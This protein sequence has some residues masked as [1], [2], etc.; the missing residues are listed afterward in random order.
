MAFPSRHSIGITGNIGSGKSE[1][2]R[3]F[4]SLGAEVISADALAKEMEEN[5]PAVKRRI[6]AQ[7]GDGL[8]SEDGRLNRKAVARLIFS[9]DAA[10]EKLNAIVH[11]VVLEAIGK[12]MEAFKK[13]SGQPP[14]IVVESA[15]IYEAGMLEMFDYIVFV[16]APA[17][18]AIERVMQREGASRGDV[19]E[20]QNAQW[21]ADE[22]I[23]DADFV[24]RNH[25]DVK[26]LEANCKFVY[27]TLRALSRPA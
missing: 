17:E 9:D 8:Y 15:L 21:P 12:R 6:I 2:C 3:V 19:T 27:S 20:R 5:D 13:E 10:K 24:I 22:K 1:V 4:A 14:F 11:P 16:D 18:S 7:F 23:A 25:S 26:A